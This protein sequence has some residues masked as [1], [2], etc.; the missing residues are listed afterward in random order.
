MPSGGEVQLRTLGI[1]AARRAIRKRL[2][3]GEIIEVE[4][5]A[6]CLLE[7]GGA[8]GWRDVLVAVTDEHILWVDL[9]RPKAG[10]RSM[11]HDDALEVSYDGEW[12]RFT[13]REPSDPSGETLVWFSFPYG[14]RGASVRSALEA[15][16]GRFGPPRPKKRPNPEGQSSG[17][18]PLRRTS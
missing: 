9:K 17:S 14:D 1:R 15:K 2:R 12:L 7:D 18:P 4:D 10:A 16:L 3:S 13:R 5:L 8:V 6:L 11:R